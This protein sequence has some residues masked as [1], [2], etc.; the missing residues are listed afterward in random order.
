MS[1]GARV[2]PFGLVVIAVI[3]ILAATVYFSLL[4]G[5]FDA[6]ND[7][8]CGRDISA[9]DQA[10][11]REAEIRCRYAYNMQLFNEEIAYNRWSFA[12][13]S[14][15]FTFQS[16][17]TALLLTLTILIVLAGLAFSY[18][19]FRRGRESSTTIKF[20]ATSIEVSSNIIGIVV[21]S[22]SL[23]FAYIYFD[24]AYKISEVGSQSE[25]VKPSS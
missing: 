1:S 7:P 9:L 6:G 18:L 11:L 2:W 14:A 8:N 5:S 4:A 19:E 23:A 21:L 20:G 25:D 10:H 22:I 15:A 3:A 12:H 17:S 24:K 16:F 13:R